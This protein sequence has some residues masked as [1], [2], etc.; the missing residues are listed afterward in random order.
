MKF[1]KNFYSAKIYPL[2]KETWEEIR[3]PGNS[4]HMVAKSLTVGAFIGIF[5]PLGLQ[6]ITLALLILV[7]RYNIIIASFIALVSNPFT[8]LP[9][10]YAGIVTGE[11]F[12][13][14]DFPWQFFSNLI[15]NPEWKNLVKFDFEAII[16]LMT[17]LFIMAIAFSAITYILSLNILNRLKKEKK[18]L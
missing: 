10:Y 14:K 2:L 3:H 8:I 6:T 18:V 12:L 13:G 11:F 17:G 15:E 1:I 4:P 16:I 9:L 5:I 7:Y